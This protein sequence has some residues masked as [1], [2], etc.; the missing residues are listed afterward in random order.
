MKRIFEGLQTGGSNVGNDRPQIR[1]GLA[2]QG[3]GA[4]GA[5][6]AGA[7]KALLQSEEFR[8]GLIK[9]VAVS[10]TS[11][12]A[13]NGTIL[14]HA[15]NDKYSP[16]STKCEKAI[17]ALD[18]FWDDI[19]SGHRFITAVHQFNTTALNMMGLG[20]LLP[21][22]QHNKEEVKWPNLG[23]EQIELIHDTAS[24]LALSNLRMIL[25]SYTHDWQRITHGEIDLYVNA[26]KK[27]NADGPFERQNLEH[28]VFDRGNITID[29][30]VASGALK[31]L[32]HH[33]VDGIPH[34]DG[35]Y[36]KNP[37][38][39]VFDRHDDMTDLLTITLQDRPK[40]PLVPVSQDE[41]VKS[42]THEPQDGT[43]THHVFHHIEHM[44]LQ[45]K[46]FDIHTIE[47]PYKG[48]WNETTRY[49]TSP[50][51]LAELRQMGHDAAQ[52]WLTENRERLLHK[53]HVEYH[54]ATP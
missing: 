17:R 32:G 22:Q 51:W 11:A 42:W 41:I 9:I 36:L 29:G 5:F 50:V 43:L 33:R 19:G 26:V 8:S 27:I 30:V 18:G 2:L 53:A 16:L 24:G 15:L 10:G 44:R 14:T 23:K 46:P 20:F 21:H 13:M 28:R 49:N 4:H 48:Y 39:D 37:E 25:G 3:G 6:A 35:A 45:G 34:Y 12:G 7:L 54:H 38:F 52:Q 31:I 1:L 40:G 47:L